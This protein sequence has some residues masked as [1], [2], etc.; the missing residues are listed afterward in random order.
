METSHRLN[1]IACLDP[2]WHFQIVQFVADNPEF[3][4]LL[5][6]TSL[7]RYSMRYN[8]NPGET[9]N[10]YAPCNIF[11]TLIYCIA[12]SG[13]NAKY[14]YAQYKQIITYLRENNCFE[15]DMVFPFK[16]QPKKKC[17]FIKI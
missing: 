4:V 6:F 13:V 15:K 8:K 12:E 11:E 10:P 17:K 1:L 9:Y 2:E 7:T 3:N 14:G 16:I 5:P